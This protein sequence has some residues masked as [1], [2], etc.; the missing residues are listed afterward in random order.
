MRNLENNLEYIWPKSTF[1]RRKYLMQEMYQ[2]F[3]EGEDWKVP[4]VSQISL[5]N[6]MRI[7]WSMILTAG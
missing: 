4:D 5:R 7:C 6:N 2:N 3:A 1:I